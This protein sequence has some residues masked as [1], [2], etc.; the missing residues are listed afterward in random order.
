MPEVNVQWTK[1]VVA[2]DKVEGKVL[3]NA[4]GVVNDEFHDYILLAI[5]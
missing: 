2:V 4:F 5:S 3:I 1:I